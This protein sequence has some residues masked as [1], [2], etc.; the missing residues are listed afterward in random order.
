MFIKKTKPFIL[1]FLIIL[2]TLCYVSANDDHIL[3]NKSILV[4]YLESGRDGIFKI[5]QIV[6]NYIIKL[7]ITVQKDLGMDYPFDIVFFFLLGVFIY[8]LK[9]LFTLQKDFIYNSFEQPDLTDMMNNVQYT[10]NK[11][12]IQRNIKFDQAEVGIT[13]NEYLV[14]SRF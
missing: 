11:L 2:V 12:E 7:H 3:S 13:Y 8:Y 14:Q 5:F 1:T 6:E 9:S 10:I 4:D